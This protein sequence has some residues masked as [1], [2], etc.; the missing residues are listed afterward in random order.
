VILRRVSLSALR[1]LAGREPEAFAVHLQDMNVMGE[2]VEERAGEP[3]RSEH[4]R[5]FIE[6]QI[7]GHQRRAELIALA[8]DIEDKLRANRAFPACQSD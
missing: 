1:L 5:P 3:F 6:R 8:K 4:A 7:A 2:A